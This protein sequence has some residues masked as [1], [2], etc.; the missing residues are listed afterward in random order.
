MII[1]NFFTSDLRKL[2]YIWP[3]FN[4]QIKGQMKAFKVNLIHFMPL[5]SSCTPWKHQKT[6][7]F[8]NFFSRGTERETS[9]RK[10]LL[11]PQKMLW[12]RRRCIACI[13]WMYCNLATKKRFEH[14][15]YK[16]TSWEF[17]EKWI[18]DTAGST[19]PNCLSIR[20]FPNLKNYFH[21]FFKKKGN[22]DQMAVFG[23]LTVRRWSVIFQF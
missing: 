13:Y 1:K 15:S 22:L 19:D 20:L 8:S 7:G 21:L 10:W 23:K 16:N 9:G 3:V 17:R 18:K 4:Q 5:V 12:R 2:I 11:T 6:S 14:S